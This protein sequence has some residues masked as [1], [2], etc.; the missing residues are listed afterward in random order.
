MNKHLKS[1]RRHIRAARRVFVGAALA[2]LVLGAI[3]LQGFVVGP[4]GSKH[5]IPNLLYKTLGRWFGIKTEF[6]QA[7]A[8]LETKRPTWYVANHMSVADFMVLGSTLRGTF[9]GKGDILGWPGIAQMAKAVKYIGIKRV[10]KDDPNFKTEHKKTIGL[11]MQN[12][13]DGF[14]TIMFPEGTTTDGKEVALFRAGLISMLYENEGLDKKGNP[15]RLDKEVVVQ[16][17]AMRVKE[18][19]GKNA[20]G[21]DEIRNLYSRQ[22]QGMSLKSIWQRLG[23]KSMTIELTAFEPLR[24]REF[25][26][27][28]D[29]I[30]QAHERVRSVV[31]P[32]QTGVKKAY[33]PG[34]E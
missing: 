20:I 31:A 23:T 25:E 16:P 14:N 29:L 24:P 11:I 26:N 10:K 13:N 28:F 33:I 21:R 34:V 17:I 5:T 19:E 27:Q 18:V 3:M 12:F 4:L 7:S 22:D 30:N 8:P 15:V 2:P 9:A 6:N 32:H 1:A